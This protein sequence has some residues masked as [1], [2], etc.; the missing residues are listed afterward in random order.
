[1]K[2]EKLPVLDAPC[3]RRALLH[4]LGIAT[5]VALVPGCM[6]QGSDVPNANMKMCG[7]DI[8]LDL[9]DPANKALTSPGGA[10]LVDGNGDTI[11]VIRLSTSEVVALS[12][13]CTHA[14]CSMNFNSGAGTLDCPCH[15][16]RFGE[17]GQ[18]IQGPARQPLKVYQASI[19][20]T[21]NTITITL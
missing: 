3:T 12:A 20:T 1:M 18:V 15:G 16:S 13:I 7:L 14:G 6:Q 2:Y 11:M 9:T 5:V 4:G 17:N 21:T 19:D 10:L 8:C